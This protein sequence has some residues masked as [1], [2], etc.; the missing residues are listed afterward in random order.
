MFGELMESN[1]RRQPKR[2]G[3]L[4][5]VAVHVGAILLGA[6][7]TAGSAPAPPTPVEPEVLTP[8][9]PPPVVNEARTNSGASSQSPSPAA[10]MM[11]KVPILDAGPSFAIPD[12]LP[13]IE[14]PLG[15]P[16]T[17][18]ERLSRSVIDGV[19]SRGTGLGP[20]SV[21]D[22]L[23]ADKPAL[24]REGNPS[25]VYPEL[26]RNAGIEGTVEVEFII[27]PNGRVRRGSIVIVRSDHAQFAD[28]VRE[29]LVR[30]SY[31][32]AEAGGRAVPVRVRQR[33]A[34]QLD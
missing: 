30:S 2:G 13:P 12:E 29:A 27:D 24:P 22:N 9:Q 11:P 17:D 21:M 31:Y 10:P 28:A 1:P 14:A 3:T 23:V 19:A 5:S 25:P 20:G 32:A 16:V 33:F 7:A 34:F 15:D 26:L 6:W 8:W 4:V 18:I